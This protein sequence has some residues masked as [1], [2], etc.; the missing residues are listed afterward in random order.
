MSFNCPFCTI[1]C[2]G[3]ATYCETCG[4]AFQTDLKFVENVTQADQQEMLIA[5][6]YERAYHEIPEFLFPKSMI[7][8]KGKIREQEVKFLVDTGASISLMNISQAGALDLSHL[9]DDK[10]QGQI[11]GVGT[12][13]IAGRIHYVEILFDFGVIPASF[14]VGRNEGLEPILGMDFIQSHGLVLDFK[15]RK[16]FIGENVLEMFNGGT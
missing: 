13:H 8:I 9:I 15:Q 4:N 2:N 1:L 12:D 11:R 6:N 14:T 16:I 10:H 7:F 5:E 3:D